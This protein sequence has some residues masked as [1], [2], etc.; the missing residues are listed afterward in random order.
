VL[1]AK[2]PRHALGSCRFPYVVI[3]GP[4]PKARRP[5]STLGLQRLHLPPATVRSQGDPLSGFSSP[6]ECH[7]YARQVSSSSAEALLDYHLHLPRFGPLQRFPSHEEPLTPR[8]PTPL[9]YVAPPG[10]L[11]LSTPCSPHGLPGLFHPGPAHG[12]QPFEA[13]LPPRVP[14]ALSSAASLS[15]LTRGPKTSGPSSGLGTPEE[16]PPRPGGFT[17]ACPAVAPLGLGPF[18]VSCPTRR[19]PVSPRP[20]LPSR[21]SSNR[22]QADLFAGAP[23]FLT[24][25]DAP[26]SLEIGQPPWDSPPL[27]PLD[28]L[29]PD[30]CWVTPRGHSVSPQSGHPL[31]TRRAPAGARRES[32]FGAHGTTASFG[33]TRSE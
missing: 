24:V 4:I 3:W 31:H 13:L 26:F 9:G 2:T 23:G 7:Q 8:G 5:D 1:P 32:R 30:W 25:Q 14:Y 10:F 20:P 28:S 21:A 12:V 6:T 16:V 27:Q 19:A 17:H 18:E 15:K 22:P 11:T 33:R 29:K